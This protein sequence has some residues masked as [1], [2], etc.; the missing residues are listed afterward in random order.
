MYLKSRLSAVVFLMIAV[1]YL[2]RPAV[3][4]QT[5]GGITGTV[6]DP[7][8]SAIPGVAVKATSDETKLVRTAKSNGSG[9]YALADLPIG[10][11]TMTYTLDGFRTERIP[12]IVVQADRTLTLP[13]K[14]AVGAAADSVTVNASPLLNAT[15]TTN[16]YV[17]D[18]AQIESIPQPTG[19]FTGDGDSSSR[20]KCRTTTGYRR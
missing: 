11:Y 2:V 12:G 17:L 16:G 20:G 4:Q 3:A 15:D 13:V 18:K 6:V 8:G 9:S 5:L 14:L 1:M 7:S 10:T 19:S